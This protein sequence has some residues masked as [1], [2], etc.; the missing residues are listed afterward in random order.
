MVWPL[1]VLIG[2]TYAQAPGQ[3]ATSPEDIPSGRGIS[4]GARGGN[5]SPPTAPQPAQAGFGG[6]G[7]FGEFGGFAAQLP[8][9]PLPSLSCTDQ[10]AKC[11]Y[12]ALIGECNKN[13]S[14]M[15]T[16]CEAACSDCTT[17]EVQLSET[18]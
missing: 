5:R 2:T 10:D 1:F 8:V 11:P 12:W 15:R 3:S 17:P 13:P 4:N 18:I 6:F 14:F 7:G 16:S 9:A